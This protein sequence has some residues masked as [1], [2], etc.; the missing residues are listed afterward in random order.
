M[1]LMN[2]C[3]RFSCSKCGY[4]AY[5]SVKLYSEKLR[6]QNFKISPIFPTCQLCG[7]E[8][9]ISKSDMNKSNSKVIVLTG[10]CGS[11]K[12]STAE[13]LMEKHGFD[14]IDGDCVMQVVKYKY[15]TNKIE[16]NSSEMYEEIAKELDV[17]IGLQK[18][19]VISNVI[20]FKDIDIY[21]KIFTERDLNY[22]IFLLQPSYTVAV[23]RSKTRTCH[24]SITP[25]EWVE[26]FYDELSVFIE[27]PSEDVIVFD[28]STYS[29]EESV[30][31]ILQIY[32]NSNTGGE[33]IIFD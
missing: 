17:L 28:N 20:T 24:T 13:M 9:T 4:I 14:V 19:I 30:D 12:S 2:N 1:N 26:Y 8:I 18:N 33:D 11:G 22:K 25:E 29:L 31:M 7:S 3:A 6:K 23:A 5:E 16:Y 32:D 10:T 27:E 21:R 15:G